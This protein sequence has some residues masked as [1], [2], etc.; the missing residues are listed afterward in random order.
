MR[1]LLVGI[2]LLLLVIAVGGLFWYNEYRYTLPTPVP[3]NYKAVSNGTIIK[4]P[5][6]VRTTKARPVL[7]HFFNPDCPCSR[8]NLKHVK[9]L[10]AQYGN[11]VDF[12]VVLVT[13]KQITEQE[14]RQRY[15]LNVPV[16]K[17]AALATACGVYSTPQAVILNA[18]N[19]LMYR[20][21]YNSS[22]YC[23]DKKTEYARLALTDVLQHMPVATLPMATKAYGCS[24]AE[25]L[26]AER[27]VQ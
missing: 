12:A 7:L 4:L 23:T 20:G 1:K 19:Q 17:N 18:Q 8:F 21:N 10:I 16:F 25:N 27:N 14:V 9:S 11:E 2:W 26:K 22:R 6:G 15:D 13:K 3:V 5:N 24:L